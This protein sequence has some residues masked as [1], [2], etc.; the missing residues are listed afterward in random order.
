MVTT[1]AVGLNEWIDNES[2]RGYNTQI[3]RKSDIREY[4]SKRNR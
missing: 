2:T 4:V 1:I 3:Q